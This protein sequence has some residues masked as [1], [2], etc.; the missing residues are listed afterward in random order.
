MAM[1]LIVFMFSKLA[2]TFVTA[3]VNDI[4]IPEY[5]FSSGYRTFCTN[6][7]LGSEKEEILSKYVFY[8]F[9]ICWKCNGIK[10]NM[11]L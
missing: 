8:Y 6:N 11:V 1:L 3:T 9:Y 5:G 4:L 7:I 10:T 2:Y